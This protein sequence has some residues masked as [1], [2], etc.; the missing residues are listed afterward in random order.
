ML[1][2]STQFVPRPDAQDQTDGYLV[3]VVIT[4]DEFLSDNNDVENNL[5]W[6]INTEIWIFD[7]RK[8]ADGPI[9]R[10]SHSKLNMGFTFHTTWLKEAISPPARDYDTKEDYDYLI[11]QQTPELRDKIQDLFNKEVYP[12]FS[13]HL[14]N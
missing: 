11:Q 13:A 6:S 9:Y 12:N 5:N 8:L 7:A 3:S 2:T 4:S 10:L 1:G 14:G